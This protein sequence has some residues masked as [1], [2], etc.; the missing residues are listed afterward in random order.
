M[1]LV[2]SQSPS[3]V[4]L[5]V[6]GGL[7]KVEGEWRAFEKDAQC[8]VFQTF[9]WLSKWQHHVGKPAG[10]RPAIVMGR[11]AE[12]ELLFIFPLAIQTR[13]LF[14]RLTWLGSDLCDYN[15]PLLSPRFTRHAE[16]FAQLWRD[17]VA[18]LRKA[19]IARFDFID[20]GKM[21]QTVG[22]QANPFLA[23]KVLDHP[24]GAHVANLGEN[25]EAYYTANRS[26]AT[27]KKERKKLR[28]LGELGE[29]RFVEAQARADRAEIL[30]TLIGQKSRWFARVGVKNI[31]AR[32]GYKEFFLD[33]ATDPAMQDI[34]HV[35]KLSVGTT[36][37][38][39]SVGLG[40][41][42][43]YCLVLSSYHDGEHGRFGPGRVHLQELLKH[44]I[45]KGF[46]WFD[47]TVGDELYKRDW[48][49]TEVRLYDHLGASSIRGWLA[50][51]GIRM[52]RRTKRLI[53]QTPVLWRAYS[54]LRSFKGRCATFS[55]P[56]AA[57]G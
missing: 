40:F 20:L 50:V 27:R 39:T 11:D 30:S 37:A 31:F 19:R 28:Q 13:G 12:G 48:S 44:A 43:C 42:G 47:F 53:K 16:D 8:T 36:A 10:V 32:A 41:G 55:Q 25:W 49:D 21:P 3:D 18:L 14:R 26:A 56:P 17:V 34:V 2:H 6:H 45:G 52:F 9:S 5:E 29:V 7:T 57:A 22:A 51:S 15:G 38:A 24:C 46:R 23:L 33:A 35:S 54:A 1:R 4:R